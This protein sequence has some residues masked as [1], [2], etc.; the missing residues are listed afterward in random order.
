MP[1]TDRVCEVCN[2]FVK[3]KNFARHKERHQRVSVMRDEDSFSDATDS[4][5]SAERNINLPHHNQTKSV[6]STTSSASAS[7][8]YLRDAVLCMLRRTTDVNIPALSRYL[9]AYFPGIPIEW[10]VPIIVSTFSAAQKVAATYAEAVLNVEDDRAILARRSM[11]RWLHGLSAVEPGRSKKFDSLMESGISSAD[12][13][14][15][16]GYSPSTNFLLDRQVPVP[17]N[18]C[19]QQQQL[20]LEMNAL[21]E[22]SRSTSLTANT[23]IVSTVT[24]QQLSTIPS[25][26]TA[27][28]AR[29]SYGVFCHLLDETFG[30]TGMD[31]QV[32]MNC[33]DSHPDVD[34]NNHQGSENSEGCT[35]DSLTSSNATSELPLSASTTVLTPV[36]V[37]G[38]EKSLTTD[39]IKDSFSLDAETSTPVTDVMLEKNNL[40]RSPTLAVNQSSSNDVNK[41]TEA[42]ESARDSV[43]VCS[44]EDLLE[45]MHEFADTLPI[46][47]TPLRTPIHQND[48]SEEDTVLQL[49]PSPFPLLEEHTSPVRISNKMSTSTKETREESKRNQSLKSNNVSS[50]VSTPVS[51]RELVKRSRGD[52]DVENCKKSKVGRSRSEQSASGGCH[53]QSHFKVA[54]KP[55]QESSARRPEKTVSSVHHKDRPE[56]RNR[57]DSHH[58]V[59][60]THLTLPT[61]R[62]V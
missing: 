14:D 57:R 9:A 31:G 18:S 22:V 50:V 11:T 54:F 16:G 4:D 49:H 45:S 26:S 1:Y 53:V 37:T 32:L 7:S 46:P 6:G 39:A 17:I 51:N 61:N 36:Y 40:V 5:V 15:I 44:L 60:Y 43:V 2:E 35:N 23:D 19:F 58:P 41:S 25:I 59:S 12:S 24:V 47:L 29:T 52:E 33:P 21:T 56:V 13:S 38:P 20:E 34:V 3:G 30:T 8:D 28:D 55:V 27:T 42:V 62:E 48:Q 10:R